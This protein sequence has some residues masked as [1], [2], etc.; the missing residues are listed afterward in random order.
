MDLFSQSLSRY[1]LANT[2]EDIFWRGVEY[3]KEGRV[4]KLKKENKRLSA[5]V[6]GSSLYEVEFRQG[7]KHAKGYCTCPYAL[8]E[9]YCKHVVALAVYWDLQKNIGFPHKEEVRNS[10]LHI[11]Y[12][13]G[14]KVEALYRDPLHADLQFLADASNYGSWVRPHAKIPLR[15]PLAQSSKAI[16]LGE[17]RLALKSVAGL[18]SRSRYDSY[19]CAGEVSAL[20]SLCYDVVIKR[21]E[22]AEKKEYLNILSECIIFYYNTYLNLIDGS[23]GVWQIPFARI[24][25]MFGE[26]AQWGVTKEDEEGLRLLLAKKITG[27]GDIFEELQTQFG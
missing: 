19:F 10:A 5:V 18:S 22:H 7:P 14:K 9:D 20:L 12:G 23:D 24:Q 6:Q 26:R 25:L 8:N 4:E 27:W 13:F 17:L 3:A 16:S 2:T 11:E 15:F 1:I 21:L